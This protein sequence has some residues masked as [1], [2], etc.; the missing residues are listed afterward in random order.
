M[1]FLRKHLSLSVATAALG[2]AFWLII[3]FS[4]MNTRLESIDT[5]LT[6]M[7]AQVQLMASPTWQQTQFNER[8]GRVLDAVRERQQ[9]AL[10]HSE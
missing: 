1:K 3:M 7:S 5:R 6:D 9:L 8:L 10:A 4:A 2:I